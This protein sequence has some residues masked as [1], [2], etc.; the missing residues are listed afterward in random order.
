MRET[1]KARAAFELF[2]GLGRDRTLPQLAEAMGRAPGYVRHLQRWSAA[3]GWMA[4]AAQHDHAQLSEAIGARAVARELVIQQLVDHGTRAAQT[5]IAV[6]SGVIPTG[7]M[8]PML[9]RH[10]A[11]VMVVEE[12]PDGTTKSVPAMRPAIPPSVQARNARHILAASLGIVP[13]KRVELSGPDKSALRLATTVVAALPDEGLA[14]LGDMIAAAKAKAE[15][16]GNP[17]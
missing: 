6:A 10:G 2:L 3:H 1:L 14:A 8:I 17:G 5:L 13:P 11:Q 7:D 15:G 9:D 12:Q 16:D 4:R